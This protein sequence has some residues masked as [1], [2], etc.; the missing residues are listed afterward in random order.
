MAGVISTGNHPKALW[1]GIQEWWGRDYGSYPDLYPGMFEVTASE[2][3]Y[4]EDVEATGFGFVPAKAEGANVAFDSES[5]GETTRYTH[6][7]YAM[8][9]VVTYE[10][11]KDNLYEKVSR[12]RT[13]ALAFSARNTIETVAANVYNR[14]FNSSYTF[15]DGVE[16]LAT[17]HPTSSG[18]QSNELATAADFS[19][20]AMEDIV[21]QIRKAK[22]DRGLR[23][24]LQPRSLVIPPDLEFEAH[25]VMKSVLQNDS[26][27]NAMN[28]LRSV[29]VIPDGIK[30]NPYLTDVDA[31][32]VRT[33]C[34]SAQKFIWRERPMFDQDN[35]FN[36][37]NAMASVY[38]RMAVGSTD[39]RGVFGSPGA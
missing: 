1:P 8:G 23:I 5:Q 2:Q 9:Y 19:E 39:H 13:T 28:A 33:N 24:Q 3:A 29:G 15:G 34:P 25:R 6:A 38:F 7:A 37:K 27:N 18:N 36:S 30:V 10:E 35:D 11:R 20:A 16:M 14:G 12:R 26:A 21:I 32:F 22:N 17:D 31:W 4:E